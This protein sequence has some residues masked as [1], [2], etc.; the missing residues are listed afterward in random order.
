MSFLTEEEVDLLTINR[1]IF[2][3]VGKNLEIPVLLNEITPPQHTDFFLGRIKTSLKGNL[4]NFLPRSNTERILR[5]IRS[6]ADNDPNCF[7]E[8]SK[9]LA[10]DFQS[11]HKGNTSQGVFFVFELLNK[12]EKLYAL[13]KYD[14]ED[15]V[16][17]VLQQNIDVAHVP[18][19]ERFH[20]SFIKK[21][22]SMQKIALVKLNGDDIEG[23]IIAVLDR[24][25]RSNISE[26]FEG[27]LQVRRIHTEK[28]LTEKLVEVLKKVFKENKHILPEHIARTGVN[29]IYESIHQGEFEFDTNNPTVP[30]TAIFGQLDEASNIVKSFTR[31]SRNMG[32]LGES[33]TVKPE[34][35]QKPKR[36]RIETTE[37]VVILFDDDNAPIRTD[38]HDGRI[39]IK[40]ITARITLDDIDTQK[41]KR[42][43]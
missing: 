43:N 33:F 7:S 28:T 41:I 22:E 36:R 11:H 10:S 2:H 3:V 35:V 42:G 34:F 9:M 37:N 32:I 19:L 16:R 17:Y 18:R 4:F 40:I 25:K 31:E 15:V 21:A 23:G 14:N 29:R 13:I 26:Y 12:H 8:Q 27:F 30:L 38:L 24:S 20:E 5:I 6:E 1:M 39:E